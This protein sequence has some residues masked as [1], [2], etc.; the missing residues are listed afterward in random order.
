MGLNVPFIAP[1]AIGV[2]VTAGAASAAVL[3]PVNSA[4]GSPKYIRIQTSGFCYIRLGGSGVVATANDYYI[5]PNNPEYLDA[6]TATYLAYL[7]DTA[8]VNLTITPLGG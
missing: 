6:T 4:G 5:S 3:L 1:D 8:A 2:T 7:Q